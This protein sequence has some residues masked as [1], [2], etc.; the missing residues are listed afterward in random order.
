MALN[1]SKLSFFE[2][3][4]NDSD[5]I[6]S[7][8]S[9]SPIIT[10]RSLDDLAH[11]FQTE[12]SNENDQYSDPLLNTPSKQEEIL[13]LSSVLKLD[14]YHCKTLFIMPFI[15]GMFYGYSLCLMSLDSEKGS[16]EE[17]FRKYGGIPSTLQRGYLHA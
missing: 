3:Q 1:L 9:P 5:A 15:Q 16:H 2:F 8:A 14:W 12:D 17:L 6:D 13:N 10:M 11:S 7:Y 4:M